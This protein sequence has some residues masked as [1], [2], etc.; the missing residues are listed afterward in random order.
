MMAGKKFS[1]VAI[2]GEEEMS[3]EGRKE[4]GGRRRHYNQ[5]RFAFLKPGLYASP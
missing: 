1:M 3:L 5:P 2:E 4:N